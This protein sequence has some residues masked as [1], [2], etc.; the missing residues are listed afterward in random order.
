MRLTGFAISHCLCWSCMCCLIGSPQYVGRCLFSQLF[1]MYVTF[2]KLALLP[3]SVDCLPF[4]MMFIIF[5][6]GGNSGG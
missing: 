2:K 6:I 1:F 4:I 3:S 5:E